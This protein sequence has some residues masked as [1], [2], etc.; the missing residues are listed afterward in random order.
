MYYYV[1][2]RLLQVM[3]GV[4]YFGWSAIIISVKRDTV[5]VERE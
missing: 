3:Y 4:L 5:S 2:V 1:Y